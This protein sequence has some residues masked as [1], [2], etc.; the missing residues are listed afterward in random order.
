MLLEKIFNQ[1]YFTGGFVRDYL[2]L[3]ESF[4]DID[5]RLYDLNSLDFKDWNVNLYTRS[6]IIQNIKF[7]C[8]TL[9]PIIDVSCNLFS[10]NKNG[11]FVRSNNNEVD[12]DKAWDLLLRKEFIFLNSSEIHR[13]IKMINNGWKLN[14]INFKKRTGLTGEIYD[15]KWKNYNSIVFKR[16]L[17]LSDKFISGVI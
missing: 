3:N 8:Q 14:S 9:D 16:Y 5:F 15:G 4:K 12:Y 13:R 7:E 1:G 2:F 6:K 10:F 11:I 17:K